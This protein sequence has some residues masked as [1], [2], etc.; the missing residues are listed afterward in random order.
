MLFKTTYDSPLKEI[1]ILT[2]EKSLLGLWFTDQKYFGAKFNLDE[3]TNQTNVI[4]KKVIAWLDAY[5]AGHQPDATSIPVDPKVT[6]YRRSVSTILQQIPYGQVWTYKQIAEKLNQRQTHQT[7]ARAVGGAVGHNP[8]S[9]IIPCHRV[10]GSDGNLTGYAG[11]IDR[12]IALLE[13]EGFS[14]DNLIKHH[15]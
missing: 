6:P 4:S 7:S 14:H 11:G 15:I 8:I 1:T 10:V 2:N 3:A 5:F 9:I 12:K 13:L